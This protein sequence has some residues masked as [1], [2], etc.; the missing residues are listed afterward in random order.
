MQSHNLFFLGM[1]PILVLKKSK[2]SK[3]FKKSPNLSPHKILKLDSAL[4]FLF[5]SL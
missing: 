3:T 1:F 2:V 4:F 5:A